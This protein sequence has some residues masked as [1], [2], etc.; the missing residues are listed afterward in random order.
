M[1]DCAQTL[2]AL[3]PTLF[4]RLPQAA[5]LVDAQGHVLAANRAA[6]SLARG[7]DLPSDLL[8]FVPSL[9]MGRA[10]GAG[11]EWSGEVQVG[12]GDGVRPFDA[13]LLQLGVQVPPQD[14]QGADGARFICLLQPSPVRGRD[15]ER[16]FRSMA[17][18]A[19]VMI[20]LAGPDRWCEWVNKPW[21]QFTGTTLDEERGNGWTQ[22]VHP[23]DLERCMGI[24][25][26]SFHARQPFVMD[27]RLR[28]HDGIYRWVLDNGVPH[29]S[30]DGRFLGYVGSCVDIHER[31][32]LE[33]RLAERTQAMRLSD[34]RQGEFLALLSHELRNPL[35][36]IANAASVLRTMEAENPTI[37]RLREIVERQVTRLRRLIDDLVDVTRVAQGQITLIK[38]PVAIDTVVRGALDGLRT[39][40]SAAG[41]TLK[42]EFPKEPAWVDGDALRLA[43]AVSAIVYNASIFSRDP[44]EILVSVQA[45]SGPARDQVQVRVKDRG[46]G[47]S[48]DFLPHVFELFARHDAG[49][50]ARRPGL[51]VGLTLARRIAMLHGGDISAS[52]DGPG[53]GAEFVIS[54]P[55]VASPAATTGSRQKP[56]VMVPEDTYRVL[57]IDP[58]PETRDVLRLQMELWGHEVQTAPT[59]EAGLRIA[60]STR[61]QIV[62][63]DIS[64]PDFEAAELL[65]PLRSSLVGM[66]VFFA[67]LNARGRNDDDEAR[68]LE[69]GFDAYLV[70][71]LRPE[72]LGRLIHA[73]ATRTT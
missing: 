67:A 52:S 36:P 63:C 13:Q 53:L 18:A 60:R 8:R 9:A 61:P 6:Q 20:W 28:R 29:T 43:Q 1:Q 19:P 65:E 45:R 64:H 73:F 57:V 48:A 72:N 33:E 22:V 17:D 4:E 27:Y 21:L 41:H 2:N 56:L 66:P 24:Y 10:L 25:S 3:G 69:A 40:L 62:L 35:A 39:K 30:G 68:A 14:S 54:L 12:S 71:P 37:G 49:T 51:G 11:E 31:K 70:K 15:G 55:Q 58:D 5:L 26:T 23:E 46:Q 7:G 34:R 44:G 50:A 59:P 42:T 32:E 16:D 38:E 47:I